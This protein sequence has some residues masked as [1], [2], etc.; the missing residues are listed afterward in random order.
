M[1]NLFDQNLYDRFGD[2]P[3]FKNMYTTDE[4]LIRLYR[5]EGVLESQLD[6][7]LDQFDEMVNARMNANPIV[8]VT[9]VS[10]NLSHLAWTSQ[11]SFSLLFDVRVWLFWVL[12]A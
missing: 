3:E 12:S 2:G 5:A 11:C 8:T 10:P 1:R 9:G 7:M 6:A 4:A